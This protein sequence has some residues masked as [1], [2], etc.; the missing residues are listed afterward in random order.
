MISSLASVV[1]KGSAHEFVGSRVKLCYNQ[2][3]GDGFKSAHK[4]LQ[5]ALAED[6]IEL[7]LI[8]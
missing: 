2:V 4:L 5:Q 8:P 7:A 6:K 1:G 3:V